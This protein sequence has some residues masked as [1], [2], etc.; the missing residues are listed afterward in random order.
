MQPNK[1]ANA[2]I[3]FKLNYFLANGSFRV[4]ARLTQLY[5]AFL[6]WFKHGRYCLIFWAIRTDVCLCP[7]LGGRPFVQCHMC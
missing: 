6:Q 5:L 3:D 2:Y 1:T 4:T 7:I